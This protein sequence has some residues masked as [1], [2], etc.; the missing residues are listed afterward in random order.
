MSNTKTRK[1]TLVRKPNEPLRLEPGEAAHV[2]VDVHKASYSVAL[3]SDRRGL[4]TTW[5]QPARAEALL[6]RLCPLRQGVARVVYE[7]GP[8][9]FS[10]ARR[11]CAEG[12]QA[13]VIA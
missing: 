4:I 11:L 1:L 9:G 13:Q 10:L 7:A 5:V 6:E 8:T 2:G 3:Y 12:F